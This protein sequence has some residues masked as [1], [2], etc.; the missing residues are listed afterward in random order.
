M[1]KIISGLV[2]VTIFLGQTLAFAQPEAA[3]D[4]SSPDPFTIHAQAGT[5]YTV[6]DPLLDIGLG[7]TFDPA[8]A[9]EWSYCNP[10]CTSPT[11][12]GAGTT[13]ALGSGLRITFSPTGDEWTA[14]VIE[15]PSLPTGTDHV[16]IN[17]TLRATGGTYNERRNY[18]IIIRRPLQLV[19]VLD[20]SGSMNCSTDADCTNYGTASSRW[21]QLTA[22]VQRFINQK[23]NSARSFYDLDDDEY[24]VVYFNGAHSPSGNAALNTLSGYG[25]FNHPTSGVTND[26]GG[27]SPSGSTSF[28]NALVEAINNRFG[29]SNANFRQVIVIISDGEQNTG[30]YLRGFGSTDIRIVESRTNDTEVDCTGGTPCS[31]YL[32]DYDIYAVASNEIP[33]T[34]SLFSGRSSSSRASTGFFDSDEISADMMAN[35]FLNVFGSLTPEY[36]DREE[37]TLIQKDSVTYQCNGDVTQLFLSASFKDPVANSY[38]YTVKKDGEIVTDSVTKIDQNP[39]F[40]NYIFDFQ[41]LH[42]F[43]SEGEWKLI[44]E[45]IVVDVQS[46][47]NIVRSSVTAPPPTNTVVLSAV[48]DDHKVDLDVEI[49]DNPVQVGEAIQPRVR[50][51]YDG[52][53]VTNAQVRLE[54]RAPGADLGAILGNHVLSGNNNLP[55]GIDASTC[56]LSKYYDIILNAPNKLIA[57]RNQTVRNFNLSHQSDGIY[58]LDN[59]SLPAEFTGNYE[60]LFSVDAA[61]AD[62]G[63]ISRKVD[64]TVNVRVGEVELIPDTTVTTVDVEKEDTRYYFDLNFNLQHQIQGQ[65]ANIGPGW[66]Y[67]IYALGSNVDNA[68]ATENCTG[69]YRLSFNSQQSNPKIRVGI[70]GQDD[71]YVGRA[72]YLDRPYLNYS[73]GLSFHAGR[74]TPGNALDID[75]D[76]GYYLE[77]DLSYRIV[78]W[79]EVELIGG[80]YSFQNTVTDGPDTHIWGG[81]LFA[82]GIFPVPGNDRISVSGMAGVGLF[83]PESQPGTSGYALGVDAD[84][85]LTDNFYVQGEVKYFDLNSPDYTFT[86]VGLGFKFRF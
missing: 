80:Y 26:M 64:R 30:H 74:T 1:K 38:R 39:F 14:K 49:L 19:F 51:L 58:T 66:G 53:A 40:R 73:V 20:K 6:A 67:G 43:P 44:Y 9:P 46:T 81:T 31:E 60:L 4:I 82:K 5:S 12:Q 52:Q 13:I 28:G 16:E 21:V 3:L 65:P 85:R 84:Y 50:L 22:G 69:G 25:S 10:P 55:D 8:N 34:G 47:V 54:S 42:D 36:I 33:A 41:Q 24:S 77:A 32:D 35:V 17:F 76:P 7:S 37:R 15:T 86:N 23:E 45:R 63:T 78:P 83:S 57:F 71:L 56:A 61:S 79:F 2:T 59:E 75:Y 72:Q 68:Y 62:F 48:V 27:I 70:L 11:S 18:R 29:G